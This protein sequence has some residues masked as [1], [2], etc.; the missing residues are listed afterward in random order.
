MNTKTDIFDSKR[1]HVST[2]ADED[3]DVLPLPLYD[4]PNCGLNIYDEKKFVIK[5]M[6]E[7]EQLSLA[8]KQSLNFNIN[9]QNSEKKDDYLNINRPEDQQKII[10]E[11]SLVNFFFFLI[12]CF[13]NKMFCSATDIF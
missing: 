5:D 10:D 12:K 1:T 7:E 3:N 9:E 11:N 4:K 6:S 2:L 8:I 13:Y